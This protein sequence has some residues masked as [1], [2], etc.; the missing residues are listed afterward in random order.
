MFTIYDPS[1]HL[2]K[3][4]EKEMKPKIHRKK[5]FTIKAK[6]KEIEN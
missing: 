5:I 4:E 1:F 2:K 3:L 6:I